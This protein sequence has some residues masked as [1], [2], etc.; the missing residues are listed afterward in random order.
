ME[1][2]VRQASIE[3]NGVCFTNTRGLEGEKHASQG[4]ELLFHDLQESSP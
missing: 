1:P 4:S 2:G 3:V